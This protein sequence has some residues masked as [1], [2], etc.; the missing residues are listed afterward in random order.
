ML[1]N[2][3]QFPFP[4]L[5]GAIISGILIDQRRE[6]GKAPAYVTVMSSIFFLLLFVLIGGNLGWLGKFG[7]PF[8]LIGDI[9]LVSA[10]CLACGLQNASVVSATHGSIR[11]THLT[12]ILTDLGIN[13]VR[14]RKVKRFS[15]EKYRQVIINKIRFG[16]FA[17]FSMGS[18]LSSL[19]FF[20]YEYFGFILPCLTSMALLVV[21]YIAESRR[22]IQGEPSVKIIP[23]KLAGELT[24]T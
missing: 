16:T 19:L 10:L 18:A 11:T 20:R 1:L 14:L 3:L 17:S 5:G 8:E 12:G 7:E 22:K 24:Q 23:S 4:F 6:S 15:K 9:V 21:S 13:L 2:F